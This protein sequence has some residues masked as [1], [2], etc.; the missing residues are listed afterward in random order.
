[1]IDRLLDYLISL[2][3]KFVRNASRTTSLR[4]KIDFWC[5][6]EYC[7]SILFYWSNEEFADISLIKNLKILQE[8]TV[9]S[10]AYKCTLYISFTSWQTRFDEQ[11]MICALWSRKL[12]APKSKYSNK[13]LDGLV[14]IINRYWYEITSNIWSFESSMSISSNNLW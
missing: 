8:P 5:H 10:T 6:V 1:M 13:S 7:K 9:A 12:R 3:N 11:I 14:S 4:M 2:I